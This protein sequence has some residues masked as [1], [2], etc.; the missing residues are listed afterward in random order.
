MLESWDF[1]ADCLEDIR[2]TVIMYLPEPQMKSMIGPFGEPTSWTIAHFDAAVQAKDKDKFLA[3]LNDVWLRA[4]ESRSV[5][6]DPGFCALFDICDGTVPG[7][8]EEYDWDDS[9]AEAAF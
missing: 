2:H 1:V 4:P 7:F 8:I 6:D 9:E 5:Y 3:I